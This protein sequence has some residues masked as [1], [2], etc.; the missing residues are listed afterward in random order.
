SAASA[1]LRRASRPAAFPPRPLRQRGG[2]TLHR[3]ADQPAA[4]QDRSRSPQSELPSDG[5]RRRLCADAGL[6]EARKFMAFRPFQI[7]K[8]F[9]PTG[10][11]WRSLIIIVAPMVILQAVVTYVF[12]DRHWQMVTERLSQNTV[13]DM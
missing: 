13:A 7:I 1:H 10:L 11:Y 4:A 12:M 6:I 8:R 9:L 2:G 5:A 3:R